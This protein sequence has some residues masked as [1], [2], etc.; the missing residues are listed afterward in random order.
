MA[1]FER[2][3]Q[4]YLTEGP[5]K[6]RNVCVSDLRER[7]GSSRPVRVRPVW[8]NIKNFIN[9]G[10]YLQKEK[11]RFELYKIRAQVHC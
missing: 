11:G 2:R 3:G 10:R 5:H 9:V 4:R 8:P 1:V 6:N 7:P